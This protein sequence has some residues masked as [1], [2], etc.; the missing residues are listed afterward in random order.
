[1]HGGRSLSGIAHPNWKD[2]RTSKYVTAG[3]LP[4]QVD[5]LHAHADGNTSLTDE[6]RL[7]RAEMMAVLQEAK[8]GRGPELVKA[9][10][11]VYREV[12]AARGAF[13]AAL[14]QVPP[15]RAGMQ[16][17]R[18][19]ETAAL[20]RLGSLC[21]HGI[22]STKAMR[23]VK[24]SMFLLHKLTGTEAK[25]LKLENE[26]MSVPKFLALLAYITELIVTHVKDA[27]ALRDIQTGLDRLML[28][29]TTVPGEVVAQS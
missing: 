9:I 2:G 5:A 16:G 13:E 6:I 23:E 18:E 8:N 22:A 3:V 24:Q 15:D 14:K 29:G 4:S 7:V 25:R 27:R 26:V 20:A 19:R 11:D 28:P 1:M 10:A 17:A 12:M 21:D